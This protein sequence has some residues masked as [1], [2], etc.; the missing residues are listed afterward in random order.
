MDNSHS[1]VLFRQQ[2]INYQ[3]NHWSGKAMLVSK[4]PMTPI[5]IFSLLFFIS[6]V[7]FIVFGEYSRRINAHGET[8]TFPHPIDI[9]VPQNGYVTDVF[10]N[11]GDVIKQDDSL[12]Q[13]NVD[14]TSHYGNLSVKK[15]SSIREQIKQTDMILTKLETNKNETINNL[16]EQIKSYTE[17][18]EKTEVILKDIKEG[19]DFTKKNI[20]DYDR[21]K[22][23]GLVNKEQQNSQRYTFYQHQGTYQSVYSQ[24]M[25]NILQITN[26]KS[27]LLTKSLEFDNQISQN[28]FQRE[29]LMR[30]LAEAEADGTLL[31][32]SPVNGKVESLSVTTG[33]MLTNGDSLGQITPLSK[34]SK[35]YVVLW[36]PNDAV[37]YVT[38]GDHVNIRYDAFPHEKFG[39]FAGEIESISFIPASIKELSSYKNSP[40]NN[41]GNIVAYYKLIIKLKHEDIEFNNKKMHISSGM[42]VQATLFL[43]N[44]PLYEWMLSPFYNVK[45]SVTGAVE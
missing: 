40:S 14:R 6:F 35:L 22:E 4:L 32:K 44:R 28:Q 42:K 38:K 33:Q 34:D 43:E 10:V 41:N 25:N 24:H 16:N 20:E 31:V 18:T 23:L 29:E 15:I 7:A 37:P 45:K 3:N 1:Q 2:A 8:I 39:Q 26:I 12:Y 17:I 36:L 27:E 19:V 9:F 5:F 21:Y 13:I 11:V 30:Q